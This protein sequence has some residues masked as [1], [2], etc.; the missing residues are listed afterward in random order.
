M[1]SELAA[2]KLPSIS[3]RK[4]IRAVGT[5]KEKRVKYRQSGGEVEVARG[6][7]EEKGRSL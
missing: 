3:V 5:K 7:E 2:S 4:E 1:K 6:G